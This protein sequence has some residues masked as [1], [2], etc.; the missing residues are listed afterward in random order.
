METGNVGM[1]HIPTKFEL[2]QTRFMFKKISAIVKRPDTKFRVRPFCDIPNFFKHK[3]R[4][5]VLKL[6][7]NMHHIHISSLHLRPDEYIPLYI[8]EKD[9]PGARIEPRPRSPRNSNSNFGS[10]ASRRL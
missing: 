10:T 7:R 5:I 1:M 3:F 2:D 6:G 4:L 8:G 9:F